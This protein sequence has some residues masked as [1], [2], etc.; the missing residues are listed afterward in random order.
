MLPGLNVKL[1]LYNNV[2]MCQANVDIYLSVWK[3]G[4]ASD[5]ADNVRRGGPDLSVAIDG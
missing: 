1:D 4:P 5:L 3:A 2:K